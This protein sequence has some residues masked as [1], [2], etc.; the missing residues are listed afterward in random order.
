[1]RNLFII[2]FVFIWAG[3]FAQ[4]KNPYIILDSLKAKYLKIEDYSAEIRIKIDVDFLNIKEKQIKVYFKQPDLI[5]VKAKGFA[6]LPKKGLNL[7]MMEFLKQDYTAIFIY[8]ENWGHTEVE[9]IKVIPTDPTSDFI[10]ATLWI[11]KKNNQLLKM[12][13]NSRSGG[14]FQTEMYYNNLPFDLPEQIEIIFDVQGIAIPFSLTG[15][16]VSKDLGREIKKTTKGKIN[17]YYTNYVVNSGLTK[18]FFNKKKK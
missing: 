18:A 13:S 5:K 15:E 8:T 7:D 2:L 16:F 4:E 9:V 6:L 12:D 14:N 10:L 11:D 3:C 1:M 17:L